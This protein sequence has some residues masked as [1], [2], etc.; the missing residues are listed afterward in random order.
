MSNP[1]NHFTSQQMQKLSADIKTWGL[2]LGFNQIGITDTDLHTAE[3]KHEEWIKKVSMVR[4]IYGKTRHQAYP[5]CRLVPNTIRVI[6][7][8]LDYLPPSAADSGTILQNATK[9]FISRYALG[10]DYHKVMRNKLQ[11]LCEKIQP[12]LADYPTGNLNTEHSLI[13]RQYG[14][15]IGRKSRFRLA[16]QTHPAYQ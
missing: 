7:A 16:R 5:P 13:A 1:V 2:A 12:K 8:R 4:W 10:R 14:S 3:T 6:S 15:G 9:A 11:K